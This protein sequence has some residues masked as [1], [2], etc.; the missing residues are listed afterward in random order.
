M[1]RDR[2][3][4]ERPRALAD[5]EWNAQG[6]YGDLRDHVLPWEEASFPGSGENLDRAAQWLEA[7]MGGHLQERAT[8][9]NCLTAAI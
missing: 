4:Q 2:T 9:H 6:R 1:R 5:H 3:D 7:T 8:E